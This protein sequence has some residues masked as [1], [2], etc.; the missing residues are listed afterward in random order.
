MAR[1]TGPARRFRFVFLAAAC[2]AAPLVLLPATARPARA[3][4]APAE[5]LSNY[6]VTTGHTLTRDCGYTTPVLSPYHGSAAGSPSAGHGGALQD[7]WLFCDTINYDPSGNIVDAVL[8]TN[9]AAEAPLVP[10]QV[11]QDLSEVATPPSAASF[12]NDNGPAPFLPV[13]T[14][15]VLP[16][17]TSPCVGAN[18]SP[19]GVYGA[20]SPGIYP[21]S[22]ITGVANEPP[23]AGGRPGDVLMAFNNYCVDGE[24]GNINTLFTDEGFGVVSYNPLTNTLGRPR[25]VFTSSGGQNL[26]RA[27]Q[28]TSPVFFGGYLYLF[29]FD[30]TASVF[31]V[32]TS[33]YVRLARAPAAGGAWQDPGNYRYWTGSGWSADYS[34]AGNLISGVTPLSIS[35]GNY[36]AVGHGLVLTAE[37]DVGGGFQVW[38]AP[39]P[40]GPWK[41]LQTGRV[42]SACTGG[43]F[44][45]YAL[46]GHPDLS[47]RSDL[48]MSYFDPGGLGHL[49]VAAF[50]WA[51]TGTGSA[52][53]ESAGLLG[54]KP[55][56]GPGAQ[57]RI[58]GLKESPPGIVTEP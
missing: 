32:C 12:P 20:Q 21:A 42:P 29:G 48:M 33:G 53:G 7:L 5:P 6:E 13:P 45:C 54:G 28:L 34:E 2:A 22:W 10:G 57:R 51:A 11:P 49:H 36:S 55:A 35:A 16:D 44:G 23:G 25:Y 43:E 37:S 56:A 52:Q 9:T 30:C 18:P 19:N 50:P 24:T 14:G 39:S 8:G 46:I 38:T 1:L 4:T 58:D 40:T 27:E 15:L 17:S 26:P 3:A 31:G 47:T 41:L